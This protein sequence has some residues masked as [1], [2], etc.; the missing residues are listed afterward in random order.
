MTKE[1]G[2]RPPFEAPCYDPVWEGHYPEVAI[3]ETYCLPRINLHQNNCRDMG[4]GRQ[5]VCDEGTACH[6]ATQQQ[7]QR[8]A[9]PRSTSAPKQS[10]ASSSW[11]R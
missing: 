1:Y 5:E 11:S 2:G 7:A 9:R 10:S 8:R 3:Y 6:L 4:D